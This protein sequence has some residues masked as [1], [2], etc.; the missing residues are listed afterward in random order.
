MP[1]LSMSVL[2]WLR[3]FGSWWVLRFSVLGQMLFVS[4]ATAVAA[5]AV[6]GNV[7][8]WW[9]LHQGTLP[10]VFGIQAVVAKALLAFG[11]VCLAAT[12]LPLCIKRLRVKTPK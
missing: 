4:A 11:Y 9:G 12:L 6:I 7:V 1:L 2:T 8:D 3:A 5:V 10:A